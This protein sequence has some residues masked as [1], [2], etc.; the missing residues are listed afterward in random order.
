MEHDGTI[1]HRLHTITSEVLDELYDLITIDDIDVTLI[2]DK[3]PFDEDVSFSRLISE[4]RPA[5]SHFIRSDQRLRELVK[6]FHSMA[7]YCSYVPN[8]TSHIA[9][10]HGLKTYHFNSQSYLPDSYS[11]HAALIHIE[12]GEK[13]GIFLIDPTFRQ[14]TVFMPHRDLKI[15]NMPGF[16]LNASN[17]V[18]YDQLVSKGY[19]QLTE[20]NVEHYLRCFQKATKKERLLPDPFILIQKQAEFVP[21][22]I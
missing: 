7:G 6:E 19:A 10:Q 9:A 8:I 4:E 12:D 14:F 1:D 17:P 20:D 3:N 2:G 5:S 18:L 11:H 21:P 13:R 16:R 15:S 22:V